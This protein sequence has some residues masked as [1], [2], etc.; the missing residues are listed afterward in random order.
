MA[1]AQCLEASRDSD[2]KPT[3]GELDLVVALSRLPLLKDA[4]AEG[5]QCDRIL[6]VLNE[7]AEELGDTLSFPKVFVLQTDVS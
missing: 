1:R 4:V 7:E 2:T 3:W 6:R 5:Q